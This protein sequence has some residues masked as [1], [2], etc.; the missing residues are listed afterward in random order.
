MSGS[1]LNLAV[2][3]LVFS[4][5]TSLVQLAE[6]LALLYAEHDLAEE[7]R[8]CDF[9]VAVVRVAGRWS[10]PKN[11]VEFRLDGRRPFLPMPQLHALPLL[12]WGLNW[13][14]ATTMNCWLIIHAAVL[15][16]EGRGLILPG[17]P[18]AGKSTLTAVLASRGWRLLS[19]EHAIIDPRSGRLIAVPRPIS[20]KNDS[21][22]LI[23]AMFPDAVMS[24]PVADTHKG[25]IAHLK[26]S[27][28]SISMASEEVR[29]AWVVFPAFGPSVQ[30]ELSAIEK[31][32]ALA[33]LAE[34]SFNYGLHGSAGFRALAD[35]V[36][37]C[38]VFELAYSSV[39][40]AADLI[41]RLAG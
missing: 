28:D 36:E 29:P 13:C 11:R 8:I 34:N 31:G 30:T 21:I 19:D 39:T 14:I 40:A 22:R 20:L 37:A 24:P 35:A 25:T 23:G 12:E 1:G 32:E 3:P 18:G 10:F 2:G 16:R 26:P 41:D 4:I 5:R 17:R 33:R 15:A 7:G 6:P 27:A 9:S 38:Q